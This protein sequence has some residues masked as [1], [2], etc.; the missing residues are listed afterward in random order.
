MVGFS[1]GRIG[2]LGKKRAVDTFES[3]MVLVLTVI[4]LVIAG[5]VPTFERGC[6]GRRI[7]HPRRLPP[8]RIRT[9]SGYTCWL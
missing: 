6:G 8:L 1:T 9:E 2:S 5:V 4:T 7:R 3:A